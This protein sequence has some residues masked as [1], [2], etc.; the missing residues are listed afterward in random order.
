[1]KRSSVLAVVGL[2]SLFQALLVGAQQPAPAAPA[3]AHKGTLQLGNFSVSLTVKDLAK[4]RA[5]YEALG[6][7]QAGGEA[8]QGWIVL[9]N[10]ECKIG[11]FQGMFERNMLTFNPGWNSA[12][13]TLAEFTDVRELQEIL[14][15]RGLTPTTRADPLS[16]GP[17]FF[18]LEDPDGNP[19]LFDQHVPMSGAP[20]EPAKR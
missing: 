19:V 14:E 11:L 20:S 2:A 16:T 18:M 9:Q 6:F 15:G 5:F 12:K 4:S 3:P 17:A 1:M 10:G 7:E 8:K 13:E